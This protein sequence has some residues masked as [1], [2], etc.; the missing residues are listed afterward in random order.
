[1]DGSVQA[2]VKIVLLSGSR[3]SKARYSHVT[4]KG[5]GDILLIAQ[6]MKELFLSS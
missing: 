4:S 1:M 3:P 2:S 6:S 5:V